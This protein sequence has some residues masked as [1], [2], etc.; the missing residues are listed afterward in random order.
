MLAAKSSQRQQGT[1]TNKRQSRNA[2]D[3]SQIEGVATGIAARMPDD[4][5]PSRNMAREENKNDKSGKTEG[6]G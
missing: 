4:G 1:I 5:K 2:L 6:H 3:P